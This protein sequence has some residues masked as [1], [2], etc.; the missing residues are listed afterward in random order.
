MLHSLQDHDAMFGDMRHMSM[1]MRGGYATISGS[2]FDSEASADEI[3]DFEDECMDVPRRGSTEWARVRANR[4]VYD[5]CSN[6]DVPTVREAAYFILHEKRTGCISDETANR[7]CMF[8]HKM[9]PENNR[10]P[11]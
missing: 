6:E 3:S 8:I 5:S 1:H 2:G 7:L 4:R 11:R 9:L 10:F